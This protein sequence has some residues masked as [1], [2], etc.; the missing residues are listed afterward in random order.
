M[1]W[2][3]EDQPDVAAEKILDAA[4]KVFI[5]RG[6]AATGMARVAE[7]AGCS[8]GTLYRY[9]PTRHA[10]HLAYVDRTAR[11]I[12]EHVRARTAGLDDPRQ[13]LVESVLA[14]V[15][16]VRA[17]PG[18]SAWFDPAVSGTAARVSRASEVVEAFTAAFVAE[19]FGGPRDGSESRLAGRWLTRVIVSLLAMPGESEQEEREI[20]ERFA[21]PGLLPAR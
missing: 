13:R 1:T 12:V 21:I 7:T 18:A 16:E 3:R 14:S 10:L 8:R 4:E 19:L 15:R 5:E 20:V 6:V 17:S 2:L 9:F 11:T